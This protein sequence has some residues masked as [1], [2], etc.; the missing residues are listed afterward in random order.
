LDK[1]HW[2]NT[3]TI[4]GDEHLVEKWGRNEEENKEWYEKWFESKTGMIIS[5]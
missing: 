3:T 2:K 1:N 5:K 4:K